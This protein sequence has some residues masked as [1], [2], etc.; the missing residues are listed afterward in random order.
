MPRPDGSQAYVGYGV[1]SITAI[2]VAICRVKFLG[3]TCDA[4]ADIYPTAE[5]G[6][7]TTAILDAAARV[8][9]LNFKYLQEGRGAVVTARFGAD[10]IT[11]VDPNRFR[12]GENAVFQRIYDRPI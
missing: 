2:L 4:V 6:R 5:D 7:I 9:D 1:D 11:I 12:E 10:G 3:E 8:R